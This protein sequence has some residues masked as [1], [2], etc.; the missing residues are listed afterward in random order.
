MYLCWVLDKDKGARPAGGRRAVAPTLTPQVSPHL[1]KIAIPLLEG[2]KSTMDTT[3]TNR[4]PEGPQGPL[5][6][7]G[8]HLTYLWWGLMGHLGPPWGTMLAS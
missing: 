5:D 3:D 7:H 6:T 4:Q 1:P 8:P 2:H